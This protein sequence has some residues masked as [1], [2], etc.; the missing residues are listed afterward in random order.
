MAEPM[1]FDVSRSSSASYINQW[2]TI[3]TGAGQTNDEMELPETVDAQRA[4]VSADDASNQYNFLNSTLVNIDTLR[5][6]VTLPQLRTG[7]GNPF[8]INDSLAQQPTT[9]TGSIIAA[10]ADRKSP[11]ADQQKT[12]NVDIGDRFRNFGHKTVDGELIDARGNWKDTGT[13]VSKDQLAAMSQK[14]RE[15]FLQKM[16]I[17]PGSYVNDG[18]AARVMTNAPENWREQTAMTGATDGAG[19]TAAVGHMDS[20]GRSIKGL[21][22]VAS[23]ALRRA[24]LSAADVSQGLGHARASKGTHEHEPGSSYTAAV[25]IRTGGKSQAEIKSTLE[26]LWAQGFAAWYRSGPKWSGN[27]H[28]HAVYAGVPMKDMLESQV[29]DFINGRTGLVGHRRETFDPP[30]AQARA[31]IS[32]LFEQRNNRVSV[33]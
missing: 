4:S 11:I 17:D 25:D 23:D 7:G 20:S 24:G 32:S 33:M 14:Q 31:T 5:F 29:S 26:K 27:E 10:G 8:N 1:D 9:G 12:W 15:T 3:Q 2:E 19:R 18:D 13:A 30:S 22:P 6:Q 16:G 21:D 28:I